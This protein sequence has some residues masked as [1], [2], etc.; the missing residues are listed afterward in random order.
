MRRG[1]SRKKKTVW[2]Q[3]LRPA[4]ILGKSLKERERENSEF[5]QILL[6]SYLLVLRKRELEPDNL[7]FLW[8]EQVLASCALWADGREE[9]R[10]QC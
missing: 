5:L 3:V 7:P 4:L 2:G 10:P 1:R 6:I 8:R 9:V